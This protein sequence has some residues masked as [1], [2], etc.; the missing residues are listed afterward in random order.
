MTVSFLSSKVHL[1]E[2]NSKPELG[3]AILDKSVNR[4]MVSNYEIDNKRSRVNFTNILRAAFT[5]VD[6]ESVK[7]AFKSS[8]S[9]YAFGIC[10]RITLMKLSPDW[11][12]KI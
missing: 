7:N 8:V 1:I 3:G 6:P 2:V 9:F 11:E 10:G 4:P 12:R 5:L